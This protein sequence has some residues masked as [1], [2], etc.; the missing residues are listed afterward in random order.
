MLCLVLGSEDAIEIP[1]EWVV[2]CN[3]ADPCALLLAMGIAACGGQVAE[4][5]G[6]FCKL[7][8]LGIPECHRALAA[9]EVAGMAMVMRITG[10]APAVTLTIGPPKP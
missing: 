2:A 3:Q 6:E 5:D 10:E 7:L 8:G 1:F 4:V 9:L